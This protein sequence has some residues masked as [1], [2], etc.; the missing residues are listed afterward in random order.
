MPG[1]ICLKD[2]S[3]KITYR[4][5]EYSLVFNINVMEEIQSE[6]GSIEKW[7]QLSDPSNGEPNVKALKFGLAAMLNEGIDIDNEK[8]GT[9]IQPLTL[10]QVGRIISEIG[11]DK[12]ANALNDTVVESTK[13]TE[14][15]A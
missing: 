9:D 13:S 4:D 6:F 7:G 12:T 15:N 14:K 3:K 5:K 8:N 11:M 1:G 2:V 10:K